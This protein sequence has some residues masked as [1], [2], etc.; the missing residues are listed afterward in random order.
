MRQLQ[1]VPFGWFYVHP[2]GTNNL[3]QIQE[4]FQAVV[5]GMPDM[6]GRLTVMLGPSPGHGL[7]EKADGKFFIF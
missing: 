7:P 2:D 4:L 6:N 3:E 5:D 1:L